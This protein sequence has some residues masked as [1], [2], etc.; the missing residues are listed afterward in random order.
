MKL[1]YSKEWYEKRIGL[2][3]ESEV[4]AG[5]LHGSP[6]SDKE[7][8][9]F[10]DTRIALGTFVSLWRRNQGWDAARLAE[11]AGIETQEILEIEHDP[12]CEPE[13]EVVRKLA[14]VFGLPAKPLL[15]QRRRNEI[16]DLTSGAKSN[17]SFRQPVISTRI[18]CCLGCHR[19]C[20]RI[21]VSHEL[22]LLFRFA[23]QQAF[24]D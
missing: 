1:K 22:V 4:G 10:V 7:K 23:V 18:T 16:R 12:H 19:F 2:E 21:V 9:T 11:K 14:K 17:F 6:E 20:E 3:G 8:V 13:P 15:E 5:Y 24:F